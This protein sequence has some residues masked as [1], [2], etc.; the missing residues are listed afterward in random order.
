[1]KKLVV[2][3]M[4]GVLTD[5]KSSWYFI[6]KYFGTDNMENI[7]LFN[8]GKIDYPTFI[9]MDVMLW[10]SKDPYLT[11][12]KLKKIYERMPMMNG[13]YET[14]KTLKEKGMK[15]AIITG[16]LDIIA[17]I[18]S[19][20]LGIEIY[21]ANGLETDRNGVITGK[22]KMVVNPYR[23]DIAL[24]NL[25]D[26]LKIKPQDTVA[27]GDGEVDVPMFKIAGTGIAFDPLSDNVEKSA[28]I[29]I[30]KKNLTEILPYIL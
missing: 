20:R 2:F 9:Y 8:E 21:Y 1:M 19:K 12:E 25:L 4:D 15:L 11:I 26:K 23:K 10:K 30:K 28:N 24:M 7:R 14:V 13:A 29:V 16:G 6:H 3:D 5:C 22:A 18:V 17:D 27:I